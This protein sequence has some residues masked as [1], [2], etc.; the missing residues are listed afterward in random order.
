MPRVLLVV[1][2]ERRHRAVIDTL[3]RQ[4]AEAWTLF[5]VALDEDAPGRLLAGQVAREDPP[6]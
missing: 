4:P 2:N 5:A 6:P 3:A 1:P